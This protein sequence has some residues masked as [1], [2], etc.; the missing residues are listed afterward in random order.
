MH[1]KFEELRAKQAGFTLV[2]L[3]IVITILGV[4]AAIVVFSVR[5][6]NDQSGTTACAS[7]VATVD[8]AVE[9]YYASN[10]AYP[11]NLAS[12]W[13]GASPLLKSSPTFNG[14]AVVS[15]SVSGT[16]TITC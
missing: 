3:L 7:D 6:I 10:G 8:A 1:R 4:L 15:N 11:A 9:A 13:S 14:G 5:G 2:E 12:L 16:I